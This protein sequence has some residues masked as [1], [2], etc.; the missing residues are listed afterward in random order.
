MDVL[1][2]LT[3]L[4]EKSLVVAEEVPPGMHDAA[5]AALDQEDALDL[6]ERMA[7][8]ALEGLGDSGAT[9]VPGQELVRDP[10][11]SR[12]RVRVYRPD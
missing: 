9:A 3:R 7:A 12:G 8:W 10:G 4:V 11:R 5:L 6:D 1:D 2:L